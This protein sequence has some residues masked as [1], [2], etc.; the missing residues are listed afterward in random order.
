MSMKHKSSIDN[1]RPHGQVLRPRTCARW[2]NVPID[3]HINRHSHPAYVAAT[4]PIL[5]C[6]VEGPTP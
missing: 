2:Q 6:S 5:V 4:A 3:Q 1:T